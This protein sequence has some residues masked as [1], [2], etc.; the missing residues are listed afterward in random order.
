M[1]RFSHFFNHG[2][3]W[4]FLLAAIKSRERWKISAFFQRIALF[5]TTF[6]FGQSFGNYLKH[7]VEEGGA[8]PESLSLTLPGFMKPSQSPFRREN[9]SPSFYLEFIENKIP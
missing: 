5:G 4:S 7:F 1:P 3:A 9:R 2:L 6:I 8:S